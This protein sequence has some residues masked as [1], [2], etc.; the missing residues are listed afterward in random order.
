[1]CGQRA[2]GRREP[3]Y[4]VGMGQFVYQSH[5][6]N[7]GGVHSARPQFE[8]RGGAA[9]ATRYNKDLPAGRPI[10][11]I[12]GGKWH[13]TAFHPGGEAGHAL[14]ETRGN[15]VHTTPQHPQH[16]PAMHAYEIRSTIRS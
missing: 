2:A 15:F 3:C 4:H 6:G 11:N 5:Y 7:L 1:M 8:L 10:Y 16:D 12:V 13:P 9:Y 14:Y